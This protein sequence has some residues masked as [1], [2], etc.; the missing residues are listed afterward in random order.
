MFSCWGHPFGVL[1]YC[2]GR[3]S[4][5]IRRLTEVRANNGNQTSLFYASQ[6]RHYE[7]WRS[8]NPLASTKKL[9][10]PKNDVSKNVVFNLKN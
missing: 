5:K 2:C 7:L 8:Q 1:F 6:L 4:P 9:D 3:D 10:T